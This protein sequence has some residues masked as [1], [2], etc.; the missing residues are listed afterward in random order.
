MAAMLD[1]LAIRSVQLGYDRNSFGIGFRP[2][3]SVSAEFR[4][5]RNEKSPFG[6]GFGIGR[7][8]TSVSVANRN[9]FSVLF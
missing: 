4:F 6:I 5:G 9:I 1:D 3:I 8:K 7:N 2:K